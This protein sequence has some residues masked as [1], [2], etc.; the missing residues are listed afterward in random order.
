MIRA[1][2]EF[3]KFRRGLSAAWFAKGLMFAGYNRSWSLI[4]Q[5]CPEQ[6][7]CNATEIILQHLAA[8]YR[9]MI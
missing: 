8:R 4:N 1:E 7:I 9:S 6:L 5:G 2:S 3:G